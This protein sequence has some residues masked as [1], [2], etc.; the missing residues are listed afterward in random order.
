MKLVHLII[1][2]LLAMF[3]KPQPVKPA[4]TVPPPAA[5]VGWLDVCLPFTKRWEGCRLTAYWDNAGAVW[6]VGYGAT[7]PDIVEGTMW[8]QAQ[9]DADLRRRL[10]VI[11]SDIAAHTPVPLNPN[12]MAALADFAYNEGIGRLLG[13]Q[14]FRHLA[15]R[16]EAAAMAEL[17]LYDKAG[18][19]VLAGLENRRRAE[20]AL[21]NS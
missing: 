14:I 7:G 3:A 5:A 6:T 11:G 19:V 9:A 17:M 2:W 1:D 20:V 4:P 13:S 10:A 21:F 12:Q 15:D 8:T 16:N 18:G